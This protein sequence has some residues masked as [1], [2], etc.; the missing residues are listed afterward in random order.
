MKNTIV[1]KMI[2][3]EKSNKN[4]W[5]TEFLNEY[6]NNYTVFSQS[7]IL[8]RDSK[9]ECITDFTLKENINACSQF[10]SG[11]ETILFDIVTL[12]LYFEIDTQN[13]IKFVIDRRKKLH[14][15]KPNG[16]VPF[17]P[18]YNNLLL[19]LFSKTFGLFNGN[20][21]NYKIEDYINPHDIQDAA[22]ANLYFSV[23]KKTNRKLLKTLP[24]E[25]INMGF[26][27]EAI[28]L[29]D[30]KGLYS[31]FRHYNE[32]QINSFVENLNLVGA[33]KIGSVILACKIHA[34]N[35]DKLKNF[36]EKIHSI[37]RRLDINFLL[38]NYLKARNSNNAEI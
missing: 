16:L 15:E 20:T 37:E 3:Y 33:N 11:T 13:T 10:F 14:L 27:T 35:K 31:F 25:I 19:R 12:M 1:I 23:V 30:D 9:L 28:N 29:I 5:Y 34:S 8:L 36:E 17:E 6:S 24:Q 7:L 26:L 21:S 32:N 2:E 22:I 18:I 38:D 4:N